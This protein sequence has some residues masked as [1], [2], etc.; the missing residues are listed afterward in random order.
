MLCGFIRYLE[1]LTFGVGERPTLRGNEQ[2][3]VDLEF[4]DMTIACKWNN[5]KQITLKCCLWT[6]FLLIKIIAQ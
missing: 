2:F 3:L 6:H 4:Q 5:L 1:V